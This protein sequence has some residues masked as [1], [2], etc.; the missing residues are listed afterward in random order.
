MNYSPF[1]LH[2]KKYPEQNGCYGS[3]CRFHCG[4]SRSFKGFT[5]STTG[6]PLGWEVLLN[7]LTFIKAYYHYF[8]W[9][10]IYLKGELVLFVTPPALQ[11]LTDVF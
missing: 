5:V 7:P 4:Q 1:G 8:S 9:S 2:P 11:N 10:A 6:L 3:C